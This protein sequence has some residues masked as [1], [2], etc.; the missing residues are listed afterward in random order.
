MGFIKK[1]REVC[2]LPSCS[3]EDMHSMASPRKPG[4]QCRTKCKAHGAR[5]TFLVAKFTESSQVC[6]H[7]SR[8]QRRGN[9]SVEPSCSRAH[10]RVGILAT[11]TQQNKK[12]FHSERQ[13][14]LFI[15]SGKLATG[16]SEVM[17][18]SNL[19]TQWETEFIEEI[20]PPSL[21]IF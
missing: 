8:Q 3:L 2:I 13:F 19:H 20:P 4:F 15:Q 21:P 12:W 17:E 14:L 10:G 1:E 16:S 9:F 18:G 7:N 6:C 5:Q 11:Q